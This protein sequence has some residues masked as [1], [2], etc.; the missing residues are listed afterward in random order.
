MSARTL[1][2]TG[3]LLKPAAVAVDNP[4]FV[5]AA[6][7]RAERYTFAVGGPAWIVTA[8]AA[9]VCMTRWMSAALNVK[10][11]PERKALDDLE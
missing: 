2:S 11:S 4:K 6:P 10:V 8:G 5:V 1:M 3:E 9:P 7:A